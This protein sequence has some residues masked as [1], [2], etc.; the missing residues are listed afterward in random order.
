MTQVFLSTTDQ[1]FAAKLKAFVL[2]AVR[3]GWTILLK[4]DTCQFWRQPRI[5][6]KDQTGQEAL[7]H[8]Y[9]L[10]C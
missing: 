8:A 3:Q 5:R 4:W 9:V 10:W 7:R 2:D 6:K 1:C